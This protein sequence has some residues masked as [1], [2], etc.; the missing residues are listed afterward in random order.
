MTE[1]PA[2]LPFHVSVQGAKVCISVR[3]AFHLERERDFKRQI[4]LAHPDH[5]HHCWACSRTRQLLRA[6]CQFEAEEARWY[7]NYGLEPPHRAVRL[8]SNGFVRSGPAV[9]ITC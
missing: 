8:V 9:G 4:R 5:N 3:D 7:A 6:R 1:I 2:P